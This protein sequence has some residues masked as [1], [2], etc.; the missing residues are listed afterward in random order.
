[1]DAITPE[2]VRTAIEAGWRMRVGR[3]L[4][5]TLYLHAPH[6]DL[7]GAGICVG[8]VDSEELAAEIMRRWN[9]AVA[10]P[11]GWAQIGHRP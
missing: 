11:D 9:S 3:K 1:M 5:R 8:I 10:L 2:G 7:D 6:E 4:R